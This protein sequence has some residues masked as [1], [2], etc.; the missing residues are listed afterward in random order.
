[1]V[2]DDLKRTF[3][4]EIQDDQETLTK[5]SR[6][7]SIFE[8]KPQL[9]VIPQ[10]SVDIQGL[11]KFIN[12]NQKDKL[13][14]TCRAAG[15]D[16]TGG[17]IN[18]SII[19]DTKNLSQLIEV[20]NDYAI[21]QPGI[22]YRDFEY[23]TLKH[24]LILPTY[25]ASREICTVG[26]M[27]ANNAGGELN[28]TYGSLSNFILEL[29]V[30]LSDGN[31]YIIK[32][33]GQDELSKKIAQKN[34]E[35]QIY[36]KIY[37][38]IIKNQ[39]LI[40]K[41]KPKVSKN[42]TGYSIWDVWDG[43]TFDLTK[44]FIGSQGTL[45]IITQIKT[46]LV[47]PKQHVAL[48]V[49]KLPDFKQLDQVINQILEFKPESFECFDKET[50]ELAI[51]FSSELLKDFKH[52]NRLMAY[53]RFLPEKF[54]TLTNNLPELVML[55]NFTGHSKEEAISQAK[56]AQ[57][58]L[59]KFNLKSEIHGDISSA[60]KYWIIR[61]KSFGLLR[62]HAESGQAS[63]F[64][65]DIIVKPEFLPEFLPKLNQLIV[66]YKHKMVY[67][68]AG[69]IGD[70]NFHII[71]LMNLADPEVR[72]IIP[73]LMEKVFNLVFEY[74]GSMSAEHN[75]GLIRGPFL[76]EMY[77][78]KMYQVFQEIK[79]IFDPNDIF[80]PHKKTDASLEYSF[81]HLLTPQD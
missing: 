81:K 7:A 53:L 68:L 39:D 49:I 23:E 29:T 57:E 36:S 9:V 27:V 21:T 12:D 13:S 30:V 66:P 61:H 54:A 56:L 71:P 70:G 67:T 35:G 77:G 18:E 45:G 14:V 60:E 24:D 19:L 38:L 33:I 55:A 15:T 1:M 11:I 51:K 20:G 5:Y 65:D 3:K 46:R 64:I 42:A 8:I 43:Q 80:N 2:T 74:H 73:E 26:G 69:H 78:Q 79:G 52:S 47:K 63:S 31:E 62:F 28:L 48:L 22:L 16:M 37:N 17:A 34:F 76:A 58:N 50:Y 32:P 6:D 40:Q 44:L 4:G 25:P 75:D 10:N 72:K 41:S 59:L